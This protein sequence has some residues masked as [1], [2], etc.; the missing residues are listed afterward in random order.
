[1][2]RSPT[3]TFV[4][5][6]TGEILEDEAAFTAALREIEERMAPLY[7]VRRELLAARS[8]RFEAWAVHKLRRRERTETQEKVVR[9]PR[10]GGRLEEKEGAAS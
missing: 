2:S 5:P 8:E 3:D 4:H 6:E 7:R 9:C 1:M 10:C